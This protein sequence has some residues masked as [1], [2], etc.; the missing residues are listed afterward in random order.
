MRFAIVR[1]SLPS[2]LAASC[3]RAGK[4]DCRRRRIGR[5]PGYPV[6]SRARTMP[7]LHT[8]K[9]KRGHCVGSGEYRACNSYGHGEQTE[10]NDS[11]L[12]QR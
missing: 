7:A 1:A 8:Y 3:A 6:A 2:R 5:A 4:R 9:V 10:R 12:K 11:W